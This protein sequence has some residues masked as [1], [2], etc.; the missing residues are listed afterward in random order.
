[1]KANSLYIEGT[2]V[3]VLDTNNVTD[4]LGTPLTGSAVTIKS[5]KTPVIGYEV[6]SKRNLAF[7]ENGVSVNHSVYEYE[8]TDPARHSR[9]ASNRNWVVQNLSGTNHANYDFMLVSDVYDLQ[10][11]D[12]NKKASYLL[13]NDIDAGVTRTNLWNDGKGFKPIKG[14]LRKFDGAGHTIKNLYIN[15]PTGY[16]VGLFE[17]MTIGTVPDAYIGNL[18]LEGGSIQGGELVGG[19]VGHFGG[20]ALRNLRNFNEVKGTK[21]VGGI[22]GA[23]AGEKSVYGTIPRHARMDNVYNGG[24]VGEFG[25]SDKVGGIVGGLNFGTIQSAANEGAVRG[26]NM[27]GGIV[28]HFQKDENRLENVYNT[29]EIIGKSIVGGLVGRIT[30][31]G[32][33]TNAYNANK[34]YADAAGGYVAGQLDI[35]YGSTTPFRNLLWVDFHDGTQA[36][37]ENVNGGIFKG[38]G[39]TGARTPAEMKDYNWTFRYSEDKGGN[40]LVASEGGQGT[41]WRMYDGQTMPLLTGLMQGT[42]TAGGKVYDGTS[43][44]GTPHIF[45]VGAGKNAGSYI[46]YGDQLGY[47]IVGR[48]V[49]RPKALTAAAA[50]SPNF[51]KVYDGTT[52]VKQYPEL[53]HYTLT[54]LVG[55]DSVGLTVT[56]GTYAD[57]NAGT[58]K[59]VTFTGLSLTGAD[60]KNY[61]LARDTLTY[62]A[63]GTITKRQ[64]TMEK[65]AGVAF[66]KVYDG[67]TAVTQPLQR[68]VNYT[69]FGLIADD[70]TDDVTLAAGA[71]GAYATK[72]AQ[73]DGARQNVTFTGLTLTGS[74]AGNYTIAG[75]TTLTNAGVIRP[76]DITIKE[77]DISYLYYDSTFQI[78]KEYDGTADTSYTPIRGRHYSLEGV[79]SGEQLDVHVGKGAYADKNAGER[80]TVTFSNLSLYDVNGVNAEKNYRLATSSFTSNLG[81]ISQK[82]VEVQVLPGVRFDKEYDG[83][84]DVTRKA[85]RDTD[86]KIL[87]VVA[88][89]ENDLDITYNFSLYQ[90]GSNAGGDR[91]VSFQDMH[92]AG[93]AKDNYYMDMLNFN[94]IGKITPKELTMEQVAGAQFTKVYDG[95][96]NVTQTL[97]SGVNYKLTGVVTNVVTGEDDIVSIDTTSAVGAYQTKNAQADGTKQNVSFTGITLMGSGAGNYTIAPTKTLTNAGKITPKALTFNLLGSTRFDKV[98]DGND[99]VTRPMVRDTDYTLDGFVGSEGT[100]IILDVGA[101]KYADKNVGVDK[102]V[103]FSGRTL[104]GAGAEN[105]TIAATSPAVGT[106]S[107]KGLTAGLVGSFDK[108]YD[109]NANVTQALA[110]GTNYLLMGSIAGDALALTGTGSYADKNAGAGKAVTFTGLTL[111]GADAG[112]Y[113]LTTATLTG[114]GTIAPKALTMEKTAGTHFTKVYD[115]NTNVTQTLQRGVN[116]TLMGAVEGEDDSVVSIDTTSAHGAY[117]TKDAQAEGTMQDVDFTGITLTGT[118]AGNYTLGSTMTIAGAGKITPKELNVDLASGVHFDKTYDGDANVTQTLSK[119]TNYTLTNFVTGEGAGITLDETVR[120]RYADKNAGADK[121]VTF[122]GLTLTGTG[123]GNYKLNRTNLTSTG[124]IAQRTLN[125]ALKAGANFDKTYDGNANVK[126]SLAKDGNYTLTNFAAGEGAGLALKDVTGQYSDKNAGTGKAVTF[127]GLTLDGEGAANYVL[128]ATTLSA[129]GDIAKRALT[130]EKTAGTHFTKVYD[131]NTNVTQTL[132]R[133]VNYTLMGAVEGEDDS[134]VSIDTTSAHGAYQTKDAQAEGTMQDVDFTGITLTGTGAGNYTLGSTMTIAGAGKITPKELNVDLASGVH[135][136]KTYDGDANVTQTLSKGTNYTLTNFVTGEGAG[137]TL[138]ETVRG[139]YADKNA[140]A[141]KAVTFDGLTLTGTGAGNYKLNRTN[142]TSTGTIAQRMLGVTFTTAPVTKV[143]DGTTNAIAALSKG[144]HY[145]LTNFAAGE[146]DGITIT[147]TGTFADKNVGTKAANFSALTLTGEGAGNYQLATTTHTGT[148]EITPRDLTLTADEK[149][150]T[151]GEALPAFT[152][153]AAGFADGED[154]SVFGTERLAFTSTVADTNTPGSYAVTGRIGSVAEGLL[155]NYRIRQAP[156]NARA[157]TVT[158]MPVSGGIFASLVQDANPVFDDGYSR[159]VY[160]FGTPRPVR[161]LTLGLYRFD[162][163]DGLEI[164]GLNL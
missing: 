108:T 54:G 85:V 81:K 5:E 57:K 119:G 43:G 55:G 144:E 35:P 161:A 65:V 80:K 34:V 39:F 137:I 155:G 3:T 136:D 151:Q 160:L 138:D 72:N 89:E 133:G 88:G 23:M 106:I 142:L 150:V 79:V 50:G 116:Y 73:A 28:G 67:T 8:S 59:G 2:N 130:M 112:N 4:K 125:L 120:G 92:L 64:L 129:I 96:T 38:E 37:G 40:Y 45:L 46:V 52:D 9:S 33:I 93:S 99:N 22:A 152:G 90:N 76:K 71:S 121:A 27:V 14:F 12:A 147:G 146:G 84:S 16:K 78:R 159:I 117:Q 123:A 148:G 6:G 19:I 26:K 140:G 68:G 107:A 24:A 58:G 25:V 11:I 21:L 63:A 109:G 48:Y 15:R 44:T 77:N 139:R 10:H 97:Q 20:G 126:Q 91:P 56:E 102:V 154:E 115:G 101:G 104:S 143:Y 157:F 156:G 66:T 135:F 113:T 7:N 162:A 31:H 74:G 60:A 128:S 149:S 1:M 18:T 75:S 30:Q 62:S 163:E 53:T 94:A 49:I 134:V 132:Q 42:K 70:D 124:T 111:T 51:T 100:G 29:G 41:P 118:G 122:D 87:G 47:D 110:L 83:T 103:T 13:K 69:L 164:Q 95:N 127:A 17:T 153:T 158:A 114:G 61:R 98:Y 141:D 86:Y 145:T 36:I 32:Y 105:Y 131:G 82:R